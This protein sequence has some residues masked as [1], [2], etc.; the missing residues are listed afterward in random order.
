[1]NL[2]FLVEGRRTEMKVYPKWLSH[3]LPELQR[4]LFFHEAQHNH[5]YLFNGNGFPSLLHNHLKNCIDE[6]N[7]SGKFD[8]LVLCLDG[9]EL[10]VEARRQEVFDFI[11]E[12]NLVLNA[13]AKLEIIVQRKCLETW[14]LGN[15]KIFKQNPSSEFLKDCVNFYNTKLNDPELMG[16]P[17]DYENS[18]SEFHFSYLK[19]LL[20]E[21]KVLYSKKN[22]QE[23]VEPYFLNELIKRQE[24]TK[25]LASLAYFLG[26]CT[27]LRQEIQHKW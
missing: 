3:L 21:R 23:V 22:P 24:K 7:E 12:Q 4:V 11:T 13:P 14:F 20:A 15:T 18:V 26:F 17:L 5:Y 2:Y 8:Y 19:E 25:H 1:M 16:R 27:K 9:D 6:L 10:E